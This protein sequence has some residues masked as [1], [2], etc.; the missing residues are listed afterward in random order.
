MTRHKDIWPDETYYPLE[1]IFNERQRQLSK[2]GIQSHPDGTGAFKPERTR[3][4][5]LTDERTEKGQLL[6]W[7]I[8][9]EEVYEALAE[10]DTDALRE[11]LVQVAAV[12]V[13]WIEDIDRREK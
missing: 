2:W 9:L 11:E 7:H 4:R 5:E 10:E 1:D 6:W 12:A 3:F 8:L 13:A